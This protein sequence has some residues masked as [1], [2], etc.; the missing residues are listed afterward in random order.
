MA[1][2]TQIEKVFNYL[3]KGNTPTEGELRT[4]LKISNATAVVS[5]LRSFLAEKNAIVEVYS[6]KRKNHKGHPVTR[7]ALGM[8]R[9]YRARLAPFGVTTQKA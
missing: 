7:Y 1:N 3:S 6:N 5:N 2:T 4:R 9:G 8:C